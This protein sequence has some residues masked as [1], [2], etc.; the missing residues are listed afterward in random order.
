[1]VA[2]R[3]PSGGRA[4][5]LWLPLIQIIGSALRVSG[6]REDGALIFAQHVE[7][8]PDVIGVIRADLRRDAGFGA[9]ECGTQ[10][11][12]EFF[13]R[14]ALI[15]KALLAEIAIEARLV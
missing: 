4:R 1:M 13:A 14:V 3:A 11:C 6:G 9:Q 5:L 8:V 10:F 15:A 7:P 12:D 2:E